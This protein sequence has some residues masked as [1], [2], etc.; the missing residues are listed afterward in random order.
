MFFQDAHNVML[1]FDDNTALFAVY[2]GHGGAEVAL[3]CSQ[4][5]PEFIKK[6]ESYKNANMAQ[7]LEE[8]FLGFDATIPTKEVMDMLKVLAGKTSM[9]LSTVI[10]L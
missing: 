5:L 4:S 1:D 3:Y 9:I 6:T 10:I 7:A 8:A 2:D